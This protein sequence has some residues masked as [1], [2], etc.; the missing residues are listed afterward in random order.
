MARP[1]VRPPHPDT[2]TRRPASTL[3]ACGLLIATPSLSLGAATKGPVASAR[4]CRQALARSL[5]K[6][7]DLGLAEVDRCTRRVAAGRTDRDCTQLRSGSPKATTYRLWEHRARAIALARCPLDTVVRARFP[8]TD[9]GGG[10]VA[11]DPTRAI[12][13]IESTIEASARGLHGAQAAVLATSSDVAPGECIGA[14]ASARSLV[15]RTTMQEA[16]RCQRTRDREATV[17]EPLDP[18]CQLPPAT[19]II[20]TAAGRIA[21]ACG[22]VTGPEIGTCGPLPDCVIDAATETG[23]ELAR[24][25]FGECGNGVVDANEQCDDGNDDPEDGCN[26]CVAPVCGDGKVDGNEAC[27]DGNQIDYDGCT[28]CQLGI[29]GDGIV[30]GGIEECDDGNDV[31][32]DGCTA[33]SY[34]PVVCSSAGVVATVTFDYDPDGFVEIAGMR[35]RLRYD[36]AVLAI[37][38]SLVGA[39]INQRVK[40]TTGLSSG[41]SFSVADRDL[42]PEGSPDGMDDTLQTIVAVSPGYVPPGPFE[43]IRFDCLGSEVRGSQVACVVDTVVDAFTNKVDDAVAAGQTRC[44]IRFETAP[45]Q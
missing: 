22:G 40:N 14:V 35:L 1:V 2:M 34:D 23:L 36:P 21:G 16:L 33:C 38:G 3:L 19:A 15:V 18:A 45:A 30:D 9:F 29:C 25:S 32:L 44:S 13:E 7:V 41:A 17:F 10:L 39:S 4:S 20:R 28:R 12:P 5:A 42:L 26:Q 37:P 27:D 43:S 6:L 8:L 24:L 31:A 11:G